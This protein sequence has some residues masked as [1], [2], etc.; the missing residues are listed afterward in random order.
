MIQKLNIFLLLLFQFN[1]KISRRH[2]KWLQLRS[3]VAKQTITVN[4]RNV[5]PEGAKF[6]SYDGLIISSS[7]IRPLHGTTITVDNKCS[8]SILVHNMRCM[9]IIIYNLTRPRRVHVINKAGHFAIRLKYYFK[10]PCLL[11]LASYNCF[12][13]NYQTS[14]QAQPVY[15]HKRVCKIAYSE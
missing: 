7:S 9:C 1:Y 5:D 12:E 15:V 4:C 14:K 13:N 2:V 3:S 6:R 11:N 10:K 8:V